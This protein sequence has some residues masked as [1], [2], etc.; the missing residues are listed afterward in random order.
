MTAN[1]I[2][3]SSEIN[4]L[5]ISNSNNQQ[6]QKQLNQ[7]NNNNNNIL[8]NKSPKSQSHPITAQKINLITKSPKSNNNHNDPNNE[9]NDSNNNFNNDPN[10]NCNDT[11]ISGSAYKYAASTISGAY[12]YMASFYPPSPQNEDNNNYD[13][14]HSKSPSSTES[15]QNGTKYDKMHQNGNGHIPSFD[16]SEPDRIKFPMTDNLDNASHS[17]LHSQLDC[18]DKNGVDVAWTKN[19]SQPLP[20]T[21]SLRSVTYKIDQKKQPSSPPVFRLIHGQAFKTDIMIDHIAMHPS[22]WYNQNI[23]LDDMSCFTIIVHLQVKSLKTSFI[24]YHVLDNIVGY[25]KNGT[26]IVDGDRS[27]T[28]LLDL[29]LVAVDNNDKQ[30]LDNRMKL[31]PR[32]VE[33]PYPVKRVVEN[34]PV[35]LGNK[36]TQKYFRGSNYLEIDSKVD[37]SMVA[38]SI[39]KLCHRFAKRIV[40]DMVWT[41]QGEQINELPERYLCGVTIHNMDFSK[42]KDIKYEMQHCH[43]LNYNKNKKNNNNDIDEF[44]ENK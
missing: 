20:D 23:S 35:L 22:S 18:I 34:R 2:D 1:Q 3:I 28:K 15:N 40:V 44:K 12:S 33:G 19:L 24:T 42:C 38:A 6:P 11:T 26:P 41:I 16:A 37:E 31:I 32:V 13:E 39:I 27:F 7:L 29:V 9:N 8:N 21:V 5:S 25:N 14:S 30:T 43:K 4:N 10:N 17:D 36:V